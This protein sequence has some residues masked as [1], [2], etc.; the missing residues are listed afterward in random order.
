ML[1]ARVVK[2]LRQR[3]KGQ[4]ANALAWCSVRPM[5]A[6]R[7]LAAEGRTARTNGGTVELQFVA[8]LETAAARQRTSGPR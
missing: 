3:P 8:V 1:D 6:N 2:R 5:S 4:P 7:P